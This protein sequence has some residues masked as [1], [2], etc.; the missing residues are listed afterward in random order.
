MSIVWL[1]H[2]TLAIIYMF[3]LRIYCFNYQV[4]FATH[5]SMEICPNSDNSASEGVK[6]FH[7]LAAELSQ[8]TFGSTRELSAS[9]LGNKL[10]ESLNLRDDQKFSSG[11]MEVCDKNGLGKEDSHAGPFL[12]ANLVSEKSLS[13]SASFP[14]SANVSLPAASVGKGIDEKTGG[15]QDKLSSVKGCNDD[16]S[17]YLRSQSLPVSI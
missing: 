10:F 6:N 16:S 14:C 12:L 17:L 8:L 9:D 15:G 11:I 7:Q 13:K 4:V 2:L 1:K 3:V 5:L